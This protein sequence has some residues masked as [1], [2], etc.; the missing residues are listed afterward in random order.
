MNQPN[1][2]PDEAIVGDMTWNRDTYEFIQS[3]L[4]LLKAKLDGWNSTALAHAALSTPYAHEVEILETMIDWGEPKL[5]DKS[6]SKITVNGISVESLRYLKAALIH[7]AWFHETE[8]LSYDKYGWPP[9]VLESMR[10]RT[11]KAHEIAES[12]KYQPATVLEDLRPDFATDR[13]NEDTN[14]W[15]VFISHAS[16]DK[17]P[18]VNDL[19]NE[20]QSIGLS[21]WYDDFTLTIG[22]SL[23]RSIDKGLARSR[24]GVVVLSPAFFEKEWPKRELDGLVALET[25]DRKVILPVWHTVDIAYVRRYSPTLAD[26]LGISSERGVKDVA[27]AI[28]Q[29]VRK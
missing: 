2:L 14:A 10:G 26:R 5:A 8:A 9:R 13:R 7:A 20:L 17:G 6:A 12:I 23:R 25:G 24:F 28:L 15:D 22:D 11:R 16:E 19:A 18:F 27:A 1:E 3:A 29:A 21:V 4:K